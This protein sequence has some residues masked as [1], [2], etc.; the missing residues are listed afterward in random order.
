MLRIV[1][2][3]SS[4]ESR[5]RVVA[6]L[7]M[8]FNAEVKDIGLMPRLSVKPLSVEELGFHSA[9]DIC[10]I[11]PELIIRDVAVAARIKRAI[12]NTPLLVRLPAAEES[13]ARIETLADL[14]VSDTFSDETT[15]LQF[16]KKVILLARKVSS[17]KE[18]LLILVDGGKGGVG[19]SSVAA[20]IAERLT[21]EE[22][23]VLL[24]D[25]DFETQ[26]L[27]RFL[28]V[29][30][31]INENLQLLFA[32]R[33]PVSE[34]FVMQS[35]YPVWGEE[36]GLFCMPPPA[37]TEDLYDPHASYSRT[38]ISVLEVLDEKFD[39][40]VVDAGSARGAFLQTLYRVA[41][42]VVLVVSNDPASLYASS[43]RLKRLRGMVFPHTQILVVENAPS[44][45]GLS[46]DVLEK[47]LSLAADLQ[48]GEWLA[49]P[50]PQRR[51]VLRWP[52]SG[53]SMLGMGTGPAAKSIEALLNMLKVLKPGAYSSVERNGFV[54]RILEVARQR[55]FGEQPD[56][57]QLDSDYV[58]TADA[59]R[60]LLGAASDAAAFPSSVEIKPQDETGK[61]RGSAAVFQFQ[62]KMGNKEAP[63][64]GHVQ[65]EGPK[66]E[67]FEA[68]FER[69]KV[70]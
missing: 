60:K 2:V 9:P 3:D 19:V 14:G 51:E 15:P 43:H 4:A 56:A 28:Q 30:P 61:K 67:E 37:E 39:A 31:F 69:A 44:K 22:K 36:D 55:F 54:S 48:D 42:R 6:E 45:F 27:S 16:L 50:I 40:I 47:E 65:V 57:L 25:C 26:D 70:G 64:E 34:E 46:R 17:P 68:L 58:Q 18:G 35:V 20:G 38:L 33:R 49:A 52:G 23:R 21:V 32:G 8:Y 13:L 10:V 66:Q 11:G 5:N 53:D 41:D 7:E 24:V 29:R 12:P 59:Q 63:P 1:V 62:A